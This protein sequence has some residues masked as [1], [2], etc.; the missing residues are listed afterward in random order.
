MSYDPSAERIIYSERI[1]YWVRHPA[2]RRYRLPLGI[3]CVLGGL[4]WFLPVL[5]LWLLPIGLLLIAQ[6][7][8]RLRWPVA[9]LMFWLEHQWLA[10]RQR[11][12]R[13][14]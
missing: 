13:K 10:L 7:V 14:R 12:P 11:W 4:L 5:G 9:R 6:D 2:A 1:I 8:R 3:L